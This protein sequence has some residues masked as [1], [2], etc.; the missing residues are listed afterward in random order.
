MLSQKLVNVVLTF[1]CLYGVHINGLPF[2]SNVLL[3][4]VG[5]ILLVL[6]WIKS[7]AR[8]AW[9]FIPKSMSLILL[10]SLLLVVTSLFSVLVNGTSDL[11]FL[12]LVVINIAKFLTVYLLAKSLKAVYGYLSFSLM[13]KYVVI[14]AVIQILLSVFM[15][16]N[17]NFY[18]LATGLLTY[19]ELATMAMGRSEGIRLLGFGTMFFYSGIIH[20]F[21]LMLIAIT[22]RIRK[23]TNI[24]Y[25]WYILSFILIFVGGMM[26]A[27]TTM[28]GFGLALLILVYKNRIFYLKITVKMRKG[29]ISL[30][31]VFVLIGTLI[32]FLPNE[33]KEKMEI[34]S[35][36]AFEMVENYIDSG[37]LETKSTNQL[38]ELYIFPSNLQT[39]IV[40]DGLWDN[41]DGLGYYMNTDVGYCRM[42]FYMGLVG[43][44]SFFYY[45][46]AMIYGM[47]KRN[48]NI[49]KFVFVLFFFYGLVLNL[50][51]FA[52]LSNLLMMFCFSE[53][54]GKIIRH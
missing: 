4:V 8:N 31:L 25:V 7:K 45:Q 13:T 33:V 10:S 48:G 20:G 35:E 43:T 36:F 24:Q 22:L 6:D 28:V 14:A 17:T 37:K 44:L 38:A 47:F 1:I 23:Y 39:W 34:A 41:A 19:S 12:K 5:G 42:L 50:K 3:G 16:L 52:D 53:R 26:L 21:V 27:R 18:E 15:F 11:Y 51:G 32:S 46:Y 9:F 40:G 2:A 54:C 49:D 30:L 29:L